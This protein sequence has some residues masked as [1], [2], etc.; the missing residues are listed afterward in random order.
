MRDPLVRKRGDQENSRQW[1]SEWTQ[2]THTVVY[3]WRSEQV[4]HTFSSADL[5]DFVCFRSGQGPALHWPLHLSGKAEQSQKPAYFVR[6]M[7]LSQRIT[8]RC[9]VL[10]PHSPTHRHDKIVATFPTAS[11]ISPDGRSLTPVTIWPKRQDN[12]GQVLRSLSLMMEQK[13]HMAVRLLFP[14]L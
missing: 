1:S 7:R 5:V 6:S 11:L 10:L 4:N 8:Y 14:W 13:F 2:P 9:L 12:S 3:R